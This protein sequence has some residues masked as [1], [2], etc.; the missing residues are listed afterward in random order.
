M[1]SLMP[2][3][4][5]VL[6]GERRTAQLNGESIRHH[7][8]WTEFTPEGPTS[9]KARRNEKKRFVIISMGIDTFYKC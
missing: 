8:R 4:S 3:K 1:K 7:H 6:L 9:K 2:K 5:F